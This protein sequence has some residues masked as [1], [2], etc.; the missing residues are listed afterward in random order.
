LR[1]VPPAGKD[2]SFALP[3]GDRAAAIGYAE[4]KNIPFGTDENYQPE[5]T[6]FAGSVT[7]IYADNITKKQT[8]TPGPCFDF[9]AKIPGKMSG[10]PI[11][12][13][14][15]ILTKGIVS[16]SRQDENHASGCPS[17]LITTNVEIWHG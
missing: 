5:L 9:D 12:V 11:L 1:A 16:R 3:F 17:A 15:G 14:S 4:M 6:V 7:N 10:S 2:P 13:G 8:M